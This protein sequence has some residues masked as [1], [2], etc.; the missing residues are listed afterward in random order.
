[1]KRIAIALVVVGACGGGTLLQNVPRANPAAVA[2]AAAAT[3]AILTAVDPNA[4]TR[5][6]EKKDDNAPREQK[7]KETVPADVLDRLDEKQADDAT[8]PPGAQP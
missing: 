6:P 8:S 1:M 5:K 2:G 3:A 4:A 7:V